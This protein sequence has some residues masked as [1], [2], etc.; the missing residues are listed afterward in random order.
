MLLIIL[1]KLW[2]SFSSP[3]TNYA[4]F[5]IKILFEIFLLSDLS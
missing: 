4:K 5:S 3:T 1:I 2:K